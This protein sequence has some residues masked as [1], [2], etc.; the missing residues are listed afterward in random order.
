MGIS[1]E[2]S[3]PGTISLAPGQFVSNKAELVTSASH[4]NDMTLMTDSI[5]Q[6]LIKVQF[7]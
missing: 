3:N 5:T 4:S 2:K 7:I 1:G 6:L